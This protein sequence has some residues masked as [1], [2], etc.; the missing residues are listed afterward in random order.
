MSRHLRQKFLKSGFPP[1]PSP[2]AL[3]IAAHGRGADGEVRDEAACNESQ[4][5][6]LQLLLHKT[7]MYAFP[8]P[9]GCMQ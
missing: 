8:C 7:H 9:F 2:C 5:T 4:R 6:W 3:E 1:L